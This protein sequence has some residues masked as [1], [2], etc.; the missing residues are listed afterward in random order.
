MTVKLIKRYKNGA[1]REL[2]VISAR[3]GDKTV[4]GIAVEDREVVI[5]HCGTA[6]G[7]PGDIVLTLADDHYLFWA[8][9]DSGL[10]ID[11]PPLAEIMAASAKE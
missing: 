7:E 1:T 8:L 3:Y 9:L 6:P 5:I 2:N 4:N 11:P 10:P